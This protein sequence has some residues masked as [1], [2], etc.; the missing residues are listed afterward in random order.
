[1][2][3]EGYLDVR[4][5]ISRTGIQ[6]YYAVEL[7]DLFS[8]YEPFAI[9]NV[10]RPADEVFSEASLA[11]FAKKPIT[12]DHP[13]EGVN[14][15]NHK[16][17]AVGFAGEKMERDGIFMAGTLRI[18]NAD[19]VNRVQRGEG[20][21]SAGYNSDI[22]REDGTFEGTPYQAVMRKILGNH[23]A[24][25]DAGRC[26]PLC[27]VGD[28]APQM[29][30]DKASA[31]DCGCSKEPDMTSTNTGPQLQAKT[32]DGKTF[33]V[34]A[35]GAILFDFQADK[36][37]AAET[38]VAELEGKLAAQ[39]TTHGDAVKKLEKDL[40]DTKAQ[41][42]DASKLDAAV[43]ERTALISDAK[44]LL[45]DKFDF[46]GKSG[47]EIRKEAV[48]KKMGDK[49]KDK[50]ATYYDSA[51]E[52]LV[53]QA[54]DRSTNDSRHGDDDG[55]DDLR[56]TFRNNDR[57]NGGEDKRDQALAKARKVRQDAWKAKA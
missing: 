7:G 37:K 14:A 5:R 24:L 44:K 13:W 35:A 3:P 46:K 38:K 34:D 6:E 30:L 45:G 21:L 32:L 22:T 23:I 28:R 11:S 33:Q 1:M 51:F 31:K 50:S 15:S 26:G 4:A 10:F 47:E 9:I 55:D 57:D 54:G 8:D 40:A 20:E 19:A 41:V 27:R 43:V 39:T 2:T 48:I 16:D 49:A 18:T 42:M 12:V 29:M 17:L 53:E 36:L 52:V 56:D 25:V